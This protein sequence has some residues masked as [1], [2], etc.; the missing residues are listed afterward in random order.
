MLYFYKQRTRLIESQAMKLAS[1]LPVGA[2]GFYDA[3]ISVVEAF[4]FGMKRQES[5]FDDGWICF[6]FPE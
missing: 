2:D 4:L 1:Q 5:G 3:Y 6:P